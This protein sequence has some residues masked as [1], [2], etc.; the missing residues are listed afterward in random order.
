MS[1]T[2]ER[3]FLKICVCVCFLHFLRSKLFGEIQPKLIKISRI[4]TRKKK[5]FLNFPNFLAEKWRDSAN[6]NRNAAPGRSDQLSERVRSVQ[7]T[8]ETARDVESDGAHES[9]PAHQSTNQDGWRMDRKKLSR[10]YICPRV[11][12]T[13]ATFLLLGFYIYSQKAKLKKIKSS[14]KIKFFLR[15]SIARFIRT[16]FQKK[17]PDFYIYI[18]FSSG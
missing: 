15:F 1:N 7:G 8:T 12:H 4:C 14:A 9:E 18:W 17:S 11:N 13:A 16:K 2:H 10:Y 3:R 6:P 5:C